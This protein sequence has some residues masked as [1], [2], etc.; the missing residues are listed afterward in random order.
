MTVL[1]VGCGRGRVTIPLA[2]AISPHG[3]VVAMDIQKDML[4]K[5][6]EKAKSANLTNIK[7][8][9]ACLGENKLEGNKFDR[10]VMVTVLGE[11]PTHIRDT[12]LQE[13]YSTLKPGGILSVT[14]IIFDPHFL[15]RSTVINMAKNIGFKEKASFGSFIAYTLHLEK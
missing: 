11:I 10:I 7:Y 12:A 14:E 4:Q 6:R 1:D 8:F 3:E 5:V 2:Q 9:H 13:L 15:R